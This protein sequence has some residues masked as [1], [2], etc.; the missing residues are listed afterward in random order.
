M[1]KLIAV[2]AALSLLLCLFAGCGKSTVEYYD[3][4]ET[5]ETAE[6]EAGNA[7]QPADEAAAPADEAAAPA[8]DENAVSIGQGG[9]GFETFPSD[10]VVA[11]VN[12]DDVTWMEYYYWLN[13]YTQYVISLAGQYGIVISDW[14]GHDLSET[15]TNADVI[16]M[17]AK[18]IITEDHVVRTEA[19]KLGITFDEADEAEI[20]SLIEQNADAILGDGDGAATEEE[21]E[22]FRDY[23]N[24][25][26]HLDEE[27]FRD[28]VSSSLLSQKLFESQYGAQGSSFTDEETLTFAEDN[29]VMAAKHI[30]LATIDTTTRE[31]LSDEE[32]AEK[33]QRADDLYAELSALVGD[34]AA[35][36]ARFDELT[37][38][39]TDDTGYAAYPDGYVF[40][41]GEMVQ[42]FEDAVKAMEVGE[43]SEVVESDYGYHIILRIPVDPDGIIGTDSNGNNVTLRYAAAT[44]Q[45]SAQLVALEDAAEII[46]SEGFE[47]PDLAAIFG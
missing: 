23:L 5:A 4:A 6:A 40:G 44:Q 28:L 37:A 30:L 21:M 43:L 17:N 19:E 27:F 29:G 1:K 13:Y 11:T 7:E 8:A 18:M 9:T 42:Q 41:E 25:G 33:K 31:A 26:M 22:A 16:L 2:I 14:N 32:I 35:L 20:T 3:E 45:F 46:W 34:P 10:M 36:E 12:G 39:Y 38:E 24:E 47:T 15:D